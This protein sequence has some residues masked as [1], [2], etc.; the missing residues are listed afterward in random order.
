MFRTSARHLDSGSDTATRSP[1]RGW[2]LGAALVVALVLFGDDGA[3]VPVETH[4]IHAKFRYATA[5]RAG[6]RTLPG[7]AVTAA[8]PLF[9]RP[10]AELRGDRLAAGARLAAAA[11]D[12][13]LWWRFEVRGPRAE[14]DRA[15]RALRDDPAIA[16]A[17]VRPDVRPASARRL[18]PASSCP[19]ETP[20]YQPY[21]GYLAQAPAGIDVPSAWIRP[22]G[23]GAGIYFADIEGGWNDRHEDLPGE[24]M[25]HAG[26]RRGM[27]RGWV[28]HGTAVLGVV[29]SRDN[30]IG[31]VGIAPDVERIVTASI[32]EIGAAAAIDLAQAE[33]RPG[34]VLLVELHAVGPRGRYLPVEYWDDVFEAVQIATGRGVV[35]V[36][37]AGNGAENLDHPAYGGKLERRVRDSGAILVGAGAPARAGYVDRS[38]LDFSNYGS[39]VDLQGWGRGVATLDYGDLQNCSAADRKYTNLFSGTSSASPVVAGAA[40]LVQAVQKARGGRPLSPARLGALLRDTGTPQT[41]GPHGPASQNIGPR[42]D[43]ARALDRLEELARE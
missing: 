5:A 42:P 30:G 17:F 18:D 3:S 2:I 21:Q 4:V 1:P 33:L 12:L 20:S 22:G 23:R 19:V 41:D 35:V 38:R 13:T 28:A 31:M 43:L 36:A 40:V 8:G 10:A 11:P 25:T 37:A 6:D 7:L 27:G 15:V 39:R 16:T 34:D 29:A 9:R 26:G 32:A 14:L 24:R